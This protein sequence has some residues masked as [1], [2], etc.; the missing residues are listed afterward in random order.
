MS[1]VQ[2]LL[3][4]CLF[5]NKLEGCSLVEV[6]GFLSSGAQASAVVGVGAQ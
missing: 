2:P 4:M 5:L 6:L 1:Q 3:K